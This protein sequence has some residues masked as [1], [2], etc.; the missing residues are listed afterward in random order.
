MSLEY[1][2]IVFDETGELHRVFRSNFRC[3]TYIAKKKKE[4]LIYTKIKMAVE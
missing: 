3:I 4:G 2:Y 1:V